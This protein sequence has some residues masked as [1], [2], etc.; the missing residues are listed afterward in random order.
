[1]RSFDSQ[2]VRRP[3]GSDR[4]Q[5]P[6]LAR[7]VSAIV[8][9]P[10]WDVED[11][12]G[13]LHTAPRRVIRLNAGEP[14]LPTPDHVEQAVRAA[15][16]SPELHRHQPPAGLPE[17]REAIAAKTARDSSLDVVAADVVVTSGGKQSVLNAVTA[18]VDHGDEVLLP[19]PYWSPH[20]VAVVLA[21]GHPISVPTSMAEG[22]KVTVDQL[23]AA[24]TNRTQAVILGSPCDPTGAVYSADELRSIGEWAAASGL[25]VIADETFEHLVYGDA[26]ALSLPSLVPTLSEQCIVLNGVAKAYAM[27]GWG[28]AWLVGPRRVVDAITTIQAHA[29][30]PASSVAQMAA[31][32]ALQSGLDP[33]MAMRAQLDHRRRRLLAAL[34]EMPG[35]EVIEPEGAFFAFPSVEACLGGSV[36]GRRVGTTLELSDVLLD[37]FGVAVLPGEAFGRFGHLRLSFTVGGEELDEGLGRLHY[38]LTEMTEGSP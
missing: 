35:V 36:A 37:H 10:A 21:G 13:R 38:C 20:R 7:R 27:T 17:L 4:V 24:V 9:S 5:R 3:V 2:L 12:A 23:E 28:V 15:S 14:S 31:A 18:V 6:G 29:I 19:A 1:M 16:R 11:R 22:F 32:A 34:G 33:V 8:P 30:S 26:V 25:W